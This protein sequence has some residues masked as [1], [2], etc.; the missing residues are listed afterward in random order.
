MLKSYEAV[1]E[2]GT[3]RWIGD[4]PTGKRMKVIVT[5]LEE[6]PSSQQFRMRQVLDRAGGCLKPAMSKEEIETGIRK[7]RSEWEREW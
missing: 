1:F 3:L 5:V 2:D 4:R 7:M 6:A